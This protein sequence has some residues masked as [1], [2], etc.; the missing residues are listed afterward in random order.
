MSVVA[1][2]VTEPNRTIVAPAP[3]KNDKVTA[4]TS[5]GV[6]AIKGGQVVDASLFEAV[7][8]AYSN[9]SNSP[10]V[11]VGMIVAVLC[12]FA[13]YNTTEGPLEFIKVSLEQIIAK[14]DTSPMIKNLAMFLAYLLGLLIKFKT[15]SISLTLFWLPYFAKPSEKHL[16]L[17]SIMSVWVVMKTTD[18]VGDL[19]LSQIYFLYTQFRTP[20][21]K[22]VLLIVGVCVFVI[23]FSNVNSYIAKTS[24]G[25]IGATS[26]DVTTLRRHG[27]AAGV[28]AKPEKPAASS[29]PSVDPPVSTPPTHML[30]IPNKDFK[31]DEPAFPD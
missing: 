25:R 16:K 27:P 1:E 7:T 29:H 6:Q 18:A 20:K 28:K 23:G 3:P 15:V 21:Y 22:M 19:L 12:A 30:G 9:L 31:L 4:V 11:A 24:T 13:E 2:P 14:A 8:V 5:T 26:D 10:M 17:S